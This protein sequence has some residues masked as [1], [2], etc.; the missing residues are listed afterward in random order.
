MRFFFVYFDCA[1]VPNGIVWY[2]KYT[3]NTE[4]E[5]K[6]VYLSWKDNFKM[7]SILFWIGDDTTRYL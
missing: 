5:Q 3:E 6:S 1:I 4:T 2:L 7:I